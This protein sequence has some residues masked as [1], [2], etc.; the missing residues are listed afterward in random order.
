MS[1]DT[2]LRL[3]RKAYRL[4]VRSQHHRP[5]LEKELPTLLAKEGLDASLALPFADE[6]DLPE[7]EDEA[8]RAQMNDLRAIQKKLG[9]VDMPD[10]ENL[11]RFVGWMMAHYTWR[12]GELDDIHHQRRQQRW[13]LRDRR[14]EAAQKAHDVLVWVRGTLSSNL[15]PEAAESILGLTERTPRFPGTL[16]TVLEMAIRR[17]RDPRPYFDETRI[18]GQVQNWDDLISQLEEIH[19]ELEEVEEAWALDQAR[20]REELRAKKRAMTRYRQVQAAGRHFIKGLMYLAGHP[21]WVKEVA[22]KPA[23]RGPAELGEDPEGGS[24]TEDGTV[25]EDGSSSGETPAP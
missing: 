21:E 10:F 17:M 1:T 24:S 23:A 16:C 4:A 9:P 5:S 13:V 2:Y 11:Q 25:V 22:D 12:T 6:A 19:R 8:V 20:E 15:R 14:E 3:C 7:T 18:R